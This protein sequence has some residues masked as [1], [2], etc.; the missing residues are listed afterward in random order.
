MGADDRKHEAREYAR[1]CQ[2]V[3]VLKPLKQVLDQMLRIDSLPL[4][5]YAK[6]AWW[7]ARVRSSMYKTAEHQLV[8]N[9]FES[10]VPTYKSLEPI[11]L[12]KIAPKKRSKAH[13][14][15]REVRRRRFDGYIF[16]RRIFGRYD[17]NR[18][19]DL[20]GCGAVLANAEKI[21]VL[22][23]DHEI[24]LMRLIEADGTLDEVRVERHRGYKVARLPA[25]GSDRWTGSSKIVGR[26]DERDKIIVL[27][28]RLGRIVRLISEADHEVT[29]RAKL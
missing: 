14:Y 13:L 29:L 2:P 7:I 21:P 20:D 12:A 10:Y 16:V 9:G 3:R 15:R 25:D 27:V 6:D 19:F 4:E 1:Y 17:I 28:Q 8:R 22:I 24:E 11:P 23:H 26:I 18:L 5:E